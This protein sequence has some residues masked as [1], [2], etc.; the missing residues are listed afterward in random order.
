MLEITFAFQKVLSPKWRRTVSLK[1][2]IKIGVEEAL[3]KRKS[4]GLG[5]RCSLKRE[6][7][8]NTLLLNSWRLT[9]RTIKDINPLEER[10]D[11]KPAIFN[12][13]KHLRV[14]LPSRGEVA[15]CWEVC[16]RSCFVPRRSTR[17]KNLINFSKVLVSNI[18][19]DIHCGNRIYRLLSL[20]VGRGPPR[21]SSSHLFWCS[22]FGSSAEPSRRPAAGSSSRAS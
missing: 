1:K 14:D 10:P 8:R 22:S 13:E 18:M 17:E 12:M 5:V 9:S 15:A 7:C 6:W 16:C 21:A 2:S 11:Y 20:S 19:S 3:Q 4:N